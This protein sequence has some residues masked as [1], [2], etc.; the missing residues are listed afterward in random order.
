MLSCSCWHSAQIICRDHLPEL[1][2][3]SSE[4]VVAT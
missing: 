3:D 4:A 2:N 1:M